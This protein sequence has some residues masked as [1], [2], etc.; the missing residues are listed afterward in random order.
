MNKRE[1]PD[2]KWGCKENQDFRKK[3]VLVLLN[4]VQ[5]PQKVFEQGFPVSWEDRKTFLNSAAL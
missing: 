1:G 5:K 4:T 2:Q 3:Q